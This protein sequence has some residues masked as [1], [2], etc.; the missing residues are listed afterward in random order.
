[1]CWRFDD[2][3]SVSS[4]DDWLVQLGQRQR[5]HRRVTDPNK[6]DECSLTLHHS[7]DDS[8]HD[9]TG[10]EDDEE[11]DEEL[12]DESIVAKAW[13]WIGGGGNDGRGDIR[14]YCACKIWNV[15]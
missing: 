10:G 3:E 14:E 1:M 8:L 7:S 9:E 2:D 13:G 4:V 6:L 12:D 11:F 5:L 15:L